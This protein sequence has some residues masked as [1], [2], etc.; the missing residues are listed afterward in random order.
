MK[1]VAEGVETVEQ[2]DLLVAA[3][4]DFGQGYL[5]AKPMPAD[6]FDRYL[7]NSVTV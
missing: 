7:E 6:D 4:C 2:R 3:G 5:F 1:V